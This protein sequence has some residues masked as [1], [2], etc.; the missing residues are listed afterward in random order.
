VTAHTFRR[1]DI[2]LMLEAG[3]P[4]PDVQAQ[5]GHDDATT[6]LNTYAKL[7]SQPHNRLV[8]RGFRMGDPGLEPGTSSLSEKRS[9]QLS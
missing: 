9:N 4:L 2:T 8:C 1:T 5:V 6:T 7:D 3:A